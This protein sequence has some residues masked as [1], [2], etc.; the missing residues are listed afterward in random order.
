MVRIAFG[1]IGN[2]VMHHAVNRQRVFPGKCFVYPNCLTMFIHEQIVRFCG[3]A[4]RHITQWLSGLYRNRII[5]SLGA[6]WNWPGERG[7]VTKTTGPVDSAQYTHQNRQCPDGMK[8][9]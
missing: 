3:P 2:D 5:G 9:V 1:S 7:L 8:A 6:R 4:Q